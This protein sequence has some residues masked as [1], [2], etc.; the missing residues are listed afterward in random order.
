MAAKKR[1]KR[2]KLKKHSWAK[3]FKENP[4]A[5]LHSHLNQPGQ[6]R[7]DWLRAQSLGRATRKAR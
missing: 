2:A 6:K 5:Y 4:E 1:K 3:F 7:R